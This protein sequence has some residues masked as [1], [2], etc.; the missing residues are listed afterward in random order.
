MLSMR[1][2]DLS[3][4]SD[5]GSVGSQKGI[6]KMIQKLENSGK[7]L[8]L[9]SKIGTVVASRYNGSRRV[10]DN[11]NG[12]TKASRLTSSSG[13]SFSLQRDENVLFAAEI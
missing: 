8:S 12:D 11:H 6:S 7:L 3:Q 10:L 4:A 5:G 13:R 9:L 2:R 1:G